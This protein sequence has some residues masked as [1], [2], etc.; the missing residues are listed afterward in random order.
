MSLMI[1]GLIIFTG[2]HLLPSFT[3]LRQRMI[4]RLGELTYKGLFALG[5]IAGVTLIVIGK[6]RAE[7]IPVWEAPAWGRQITYLF[8]P[9]AF[10]LVTAAYLPSNIKRFTRHPM[11]WGVLIW[12]VT[13]LLSN[14]DL[15]SMVLF[16]G[17]AAFAVLDMVSSNIRGTRIADVKHS[18]Y[19]DLAAVVTGS[20]IYALVLLIHPASSPVLMLG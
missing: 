13:H 9:V 11:L 3:T 8:M 5:A 15:A 20:G 6:S 14:T 2:I 16:T 10:M 7:F 12:S 1:L 4:D 18:V 17:I 19:Y